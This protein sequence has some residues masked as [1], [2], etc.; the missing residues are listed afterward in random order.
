MPLRPEHERLRAIFAQPGFQW[1]LD[2]LA[3]RMRSGRALSGSLVHA[4][5]T[6]EERRAVD[7]LLGRRS[8]AGSSL[9]LDLAALEHTLRAAGLIETLEDLVLACR[10]AVANRRE[11]AERQRASWQALFD[12][13]RAQC[14]GESALREW[15]DGL[16]G[17]GTLKRLAGG[18]L[19]RATEL[20][21]SAVR[22]L[23]QSRQEEILLANLA[24]Q[25]AGDS[26]AL[27]RGEPLATLCLRA[28]AIRHGTDG[29]RSAEAR[30]EAWAAAGVIIDDLSA[31]A[32]VFNLR[33]A[34]D[35]PLEELLGLHRA[36]GQPAF[37]TYRQLRTGTPF[38]PLDPAMRVVF[39][40]ENP[41]VVSAAALEIGPRCP[42]LICTN[43]Q[44]AS[45]VR[46]LLSQLRRAGAELY[47]HA[48]FDGAGLRIVDQLIRD[49]SAT[50]WRMSAGD[51]LAAS[52]AVPLTSPPIP[53]DWS[54]GLS[55]AL[56][57]SGK[58]VYEEQIMQTL[59]QDLRAYGERGMSDV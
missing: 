6:A 41:S 59:L 29:Q 47:C 15:V 18:D 10:G 38:D 26:H 19:T 46:L 14:E 56:Q 27:D 3:A 25:F 42:P 35:A 32:L 44:P 23:S 31:P 57:A 54:P 30:R 28:L 11:E 48:D 39:V 37:L 7:D 5:A 43:G 50:P 20:L 22:I 9:T 53:A 16:A 24:A 2:R 4:S 17:D 8:T 33:A 58:A 34:A 21:E 13:A 55:A 1:I 51:Y 36:Q 52:G 49:H 40:C 45:A 12:A